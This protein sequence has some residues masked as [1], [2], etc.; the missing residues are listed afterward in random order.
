MDDRL[1]NSVL[2]KSQGETS[3]HIGKSG[4]CMTGMSR[5]WPGEDTRMDPAL[6]SL[7]MFSNNGRIQSI[8]KESGG[9]E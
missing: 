2:A 9:F 7:K 8:M 4:D 6:K 3:L 5:S 1:K